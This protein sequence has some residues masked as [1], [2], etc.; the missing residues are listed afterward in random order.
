MDLYQSIVNQ[1]ANALD[2]DV[3]SGDISAELIDARMQ[4]QTE[5]LVREDAVLCGCEWFDEVFRQCDAAITTR[6][7]ARDGD[8]IAAG[9]IVCEV[10]GPARGLLTAE[11]SA[12][13]FLQTLSGTATVTRRY[14]NLIRHTGCRI[15]DT[16]QGLQKV[17]RA[18]LN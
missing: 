15:L 16:R 3:G 7:Q 12:L 9:S 8:P 18:A 1:V 11:R 5:L 4:L 2:E 6:W 14:A 17:E 13:N 10:A